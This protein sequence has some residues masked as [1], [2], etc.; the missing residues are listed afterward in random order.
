MTF[1]E[2][3]IGDFFV[4]KNAAFPALWKKNAEESMLSMVDGELR[5]VSG[6]KRKPVV[7]VAF[8]VEIMKEN[9]PKVKNEES[10]RIRDLAEQSGRRIN[11]R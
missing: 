5:F 2:L 8:N 3:A 11:S 9:L 7:P 10:Q 6:L 1:E 4:F